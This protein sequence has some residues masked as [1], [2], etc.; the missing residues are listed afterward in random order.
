MRVLEELYI[1]GHIGRFNRLNIQIVFLPSSGVP[2]V[3]W[4]EK[5]SNEMPT[6]LCLL[7]LIIVEEERNRRSMRFSTGKKNDQSLNAFG[8]CRGEI[9]VESCQT[10]IAKMHVVLKRHLMNFIIISFDT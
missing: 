7:Q 1:A 9:S 4:V 10:I 6:D 2:Y 5:E 8:R 3:T